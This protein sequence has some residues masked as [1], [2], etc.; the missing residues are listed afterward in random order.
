[1]QLQQQIQQWV[2]NGEEATVRK[3]IPQ[4]GNNHAVLSEGA[5]VKPH[6][7]AR[8]LCRSTHAHLQLHLQTFHPYGRAAGE[9]TETVG[10]ARNAHMYVLCCIGLSN[11][12]PLI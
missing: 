10:T 8:A 6:L 2:H 3:I 7:R 4:P 11:R 5:T 9:E 12:T 1:M